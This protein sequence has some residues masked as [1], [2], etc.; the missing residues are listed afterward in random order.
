MTFYSVEGRPEDIRG[1]D[2]AALMRIPYEVL[3]RHR[4]I[5]EG[6]LKDEDTVITGEVEKIIESFD[7]G[8]QRSSF[9]L[10]DGIGKVGYRQN[11]YNTLMFVLLNLSHAV[12]PLLHEMWKEIK[13]YSK[14]GSGLTVLSKDEIYEMLSKQRH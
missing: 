7:S 13:A 11:D 6:L 5:D 4:D 3:K 10:P 14:N 8:V 1:E 9:L 12:V 2:I